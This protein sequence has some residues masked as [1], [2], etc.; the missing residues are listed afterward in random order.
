MVFLINMSD[1]IYSLTSSAVTSDELMSRKTLWNQLGMRRKMKSF[2]FVVVILKIGSTCKGKSPCVQ[3]INRYLTAV[4]SDSY[5][6]TNDLLKNCYFLSKIPVSHCKW[7][8][9]QVSESWTYVTIWELPVK[10]FCDHSVI[11]DH[12]CDHGCDHAFYLDH[13]FGIAWSQ[14]D[15][16]GSD[17]TR[18]HSCHA[19]MRVITA[20]SP[21]SRYSYGD[22]QT[23]FSR[24]EQ[25]R[26]LENDVPKLI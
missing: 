4:L 21:W 24:R 9:D 6:I 1:L 5:C 3:L 10:I 25:D 26:S 20:N 19:V 7:E 22:R 2:I 15:G 12:A 23:T 8:S 18:D 13:A 17:H 14:C 11:T 16:I